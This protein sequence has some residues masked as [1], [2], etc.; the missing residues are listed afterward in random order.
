[1]VENRSPWWRGARGEWWVAVQVVLML[2]VFFGPRNAPGWPAWPEPVARVA[3][4]V[5]IALL[6]VGLVLFL[7]G[8]LS[9]GRRNLTPLPAPREHA[10]LV[11]SGAYAWVRHPLYGGGILIGYGYA[12]VVQGWLTLAYAT[13]LLVFGDRK[14]AREERWLVETFPDYPEYRRQV[15]KLIPFL[16]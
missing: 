1:M 4:V 11:G 12:L 7:A 2:L 3:T 8:A 6:A 10:T 14:A 5:G 9:L 15:R 16:Y 13:A